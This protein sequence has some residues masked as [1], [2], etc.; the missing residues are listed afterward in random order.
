MTTDLEADVLIVGG[1]SAGCVLAARLSE[2]P[3]L[4]VLLVEAGP[5]YRDTPPA[6]IADLFP[7]AYANPA[8]FMAH[9]DVAMTSAQDRRAFTQARLL[10]GG[11]AVMGM[12]AL[13]GLAGDYDGWAA[14]G[15]TGWSFADCLPAF[16]RLET[17]LDM[18][19]P[20]HGKGGP[21]P[22]LRVPC[23]VWPGF[24]R[25]ILAAA[26]AR[27][28]TRRADLNGEDGDG[29]YPLPISA[30][31]QGRGASTRYL[32][33]G[34]RARPNLR[35]LDRTEIDRLTLD[36]GRT[37]TG[38]LGRGQGNAPVTIRAG[39]TIL[40]AGAIG[41]PVL[42]QRSGLGPGAMLQAAGIDVI[43]D[44][45]QIGANLQNHVFLHLAGFVPRAQRQPRNL[46]SYVTSVIRLTSSAADA[47]ASDLMLS[48]IS[49]PGV[50]PGGA[51]V[52][53]LGVHLN[54]PK[55]R[56]TVG[57]R[58]TAQGGLAPDI[59]FRL[60]TDPCDRSRLVEAAGIGRDLLAALGKAG[61][62]HDPFVVP[63][64]API[65]A[66]NAPGPGAA[67]RT[68]GLAAIAALPSPLRRAA[69]G[70]LLPGVAFMGGLDPAEF[71][72]RVLGSALPMFHVAGSC[73]IGTVLDPGLRVLGVGGL[74]VADAS[75]MPRLPRGNTNIPTVMLA[76]RG[77]D[78]I[79]ADLR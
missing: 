2:D 49:R 50:H 54:A 34:T 68:A 67:L 1:G 6:D 26:L 48:V 16:R 32:D 65:R 72:S 61:Q 58:R 53:M 59:D 44:L 27:G 5:D 3:A 20:L 10:G 37:V 9:P 55:S 47:P 33:A 31:D 18:D 14:N 17:D 76:E 79:K 11:S 19:G 57:L 29:L 40:A 43:A 22:I 73:A 62:I 52:A 66:L 36:P 35:I 70:R 12:W 60:L 64:T 41:T 39:R 13:R 42:L 69:L 24:A 63:A 28:I 77:A 23:A 71:A 8:Y 56:G 38:A 7:R 74:Y 25:A 21:I 46:R 30:D 15:A 75:A 51:S 78:L 4:R 45:P